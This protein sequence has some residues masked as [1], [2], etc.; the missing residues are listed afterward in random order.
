M[1]FLLATVASA[2]D[3]VPD[4]VPPF[5]L[6]SY[7][8]AQASTDL[9]GGR[10]EPTNIVAF[11][12]RLEADPY[13]EIDLGWQKWTDDGARFRA[14]ITPAIA[15]EP[16]HYDGQWDAD[17]A[18]RNLFAEA[19]L[20]AG[21]GTANVWAGSRMY[22]GDDIYLLN[23][24]PLDM[25]NTYG[26][27][28]GFT[29]ERFD[30]AGHV[31][32]NRIDVDDWQVQRWSRPVP[33]GVGED[34]VV[35]L[36]RQRRIA[37]L[38]A[39]TSVPLGD[40]TVRVKGYGELHQLPEGT[41]LLDDEIEEVLPADRG[42]VVGAQL[43]AW[44]WADGGFVH[45]FY[46]RATGLGAYGELAVPDDGF[47]TDYTVTAAR[48]QRVALAFGH[49][50]QERVSLAGGAYVRQYTDADGLAVDIDDGWES[51]M[52][53]R[54]AVNIGQ[55]VALGLEG[56]HQWVRPNGL[57]P[58]TDEHDIPQI[59]KLSVL[60][61]VKPAPTTF[62]RPMIHLTYTASFL[63]ED[64]IQWFD[65]LDERAQ[66]SVQHFVGIGAEWW[67]NSQSYR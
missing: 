53:L 10:G 39:S 45:L 66:E 31:G 44:G 14:L 34:S 52:A 11:G 65:P 51:A 62:S 30:V 7:G 1:L 64:A 17:L 24:W 3:T 59:T 9:A 33:G 67:M 5:I 12:P 56:S 41:R 18:I 26:G 20:P 61:M 19:Q 38:K 58:R 49:E 23:F 8:R 35:I 37:S 36:D 28:A 54:P 25:L 13:A 40:V 50:F 6:G 2:E 43:S 32:F 47:A 22:R 42:S 16:F 21:P 27:G 4:D 29:H 48:E 15:G 57:N 55:H 46:R 63:D 60:P